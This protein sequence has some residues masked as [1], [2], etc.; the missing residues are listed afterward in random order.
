VQTKSKNTSQ[1]TTSKIIII[2]IQATISSA[3]VDC[4]SSMIL[5]WVSLRLNFR[6]KV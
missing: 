2:C 6:L 4:V 5:R 3:M 1:Q